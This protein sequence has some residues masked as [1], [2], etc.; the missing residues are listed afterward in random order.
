R[1]TDALGIL[2]GAEQLGLRGRGVRIDLDNVRYLPR[3]SILHW[4][5]K[6]FVVL[7]RVRRGKVDIVDPAFGRR[8]IPLDRFSKHFTGVAL[9]FEPA[10]TFV[11]TPAG[12]SKVWRYLGQLTAQ[13][14][15][16]ARVLV[17]SVAL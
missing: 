15:L 1:G 8:T 4:D 9:A 3:A 13:R 12:R 10:D 11:A 17:M 2:K 5:F 7:E 6:H 14:S 16:V